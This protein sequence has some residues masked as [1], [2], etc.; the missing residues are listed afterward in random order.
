MTH[1][2]V[3]F[4]QTWCTV[5]ARTSEET[6][7]SDMK[8]YF[9]C[10]AAGLCSNLCLLKDPT[11]SLRYYS[12]VSG[13]ASL[14][15]PRQHQNSIN[16]PGRATSTFNIDYP[17]D[18]GKVVNTSVQTD[19]SKMPGPPYKS[20]FSTSFESPI[21]RRDFSYYDYDYEDTLPQER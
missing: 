14:W 13:V 17:I 21:K 4:I 9:W 11:W 8:L 1:L 5:H 7:S 6:H 10:L 2:A 3:N 16:N 19:T 12:G 15:T 18:Y 20:A